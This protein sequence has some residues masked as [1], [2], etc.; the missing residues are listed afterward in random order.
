MTKNTDPNMKAAQAVLGYLRVTF[1]KRVLT[2]PEK[3]DR[4]MLEV[5]VFMENGPLEVR[6]FVR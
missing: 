3:F 4:F 5:T 2:N 1:P 6:K